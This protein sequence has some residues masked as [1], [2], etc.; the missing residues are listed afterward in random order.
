MMMAAGKTGPFIGLPELIR[1]MLQRPKVTAIVTAKMM[2]SFA[3]VLRALRR[4]ELRRRGWGGRRAHWASC[5]VAV[6]KRMEE[7]ISGMRKSRATRQ[8]HWI[9]LRP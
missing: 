7:M 2:A 8:V 6:L 1:V 3:K 4:E 9:K 5:G